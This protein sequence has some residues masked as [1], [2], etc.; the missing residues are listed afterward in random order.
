[1][2][3]GFICL[4]LAAAAAVL[5]EPTPEAHQSD[6]P[7][8]IQQ[9]SP[10]EEASKAAQ[11]EDESKSKKDVSAASEGS[12]PPVPPA[13]KELTTAELKLILAPIFENSKQKSEAAGKTPAS[14]PYATKAAAP[15]GGLVSRIVAAGKRLVSR[16]MSWKGVR[17][18]WGG[19][20]RR[21]VDCSG[22]TQLIFAKE[23]IRLHHS[24]RLQF[25]MGRPVSRRSL[26]AGDLVFFNTRGPISHV[27]MYIGDGKFIHAANRTRG[28]RVDYLNSPY[29][30]KRYAGA[31]RYLSN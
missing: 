20:S 11:Q 30:S 23:G 3:L 5:A 6:E 22:L 19:S 18:V 21:G 8:V 31:R 24:A 2:I 12:T 29:Y 14:E 17:Y 9:S 13:G 1:M 28:V 25:R 26:L 16:A 15:K 4:I 7:K 27:G 10:P